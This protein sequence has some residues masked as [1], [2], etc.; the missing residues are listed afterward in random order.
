MIMDKKVEFD[1]L[2]KTLNT[3]DQ[4]TNIFDIGKCIICQ[5]ECADPLKS[6]DHGRTRVREASDIRCDIVMERLKLIKPDLWY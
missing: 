2:N 1:L 4:G 3:P 6:T 5:K